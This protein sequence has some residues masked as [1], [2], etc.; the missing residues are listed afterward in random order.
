MYNIVKFVIRYQFFILFILLESIA[1]VLLI[2]NNNYH[3]AKYV[4]TS[5]F[6][7]GGLY[8]TN[9][10][11]KDYFYLRTLN[12]KLSEENARLKEK[13]K[14]IEYIE[15][16][17]LYNDSTLKIDSII[18]DSVQQPKYIVARVISNSVNKPLN[19]IYINKG[20]KD[21]FKKDMAVIGTKGL[22]GLVRT[23]SSKYA[24]ITPIINK[25]FNVNAK[26]KNSGYFGNLSWNGKDP[27]YAQ[28][29]D[30]PSHYLPKIGDTII[31]SGYS[32][33][34]REGELIGYIEAIEDVPGKSFLTINVQLAEDFGNLN[35]VY[36]VQTKSKPE[37]D[38]L[39]LDDVQF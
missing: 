1:T 32:Q 31:T 39:Y 9:T 14:T 12:K 11:I 10:L 25:E 20:I 21:G 34:F 27:S 8:N 24:T 36:G 6:I 4:N 7:T 33:I 17:V 18:I 37:L 16:P 35:Y 28:L 23:V 26:I 22:V 5:N 30:I 3:Q 19:S 15:I 2:A 38:S 29:N 13:I